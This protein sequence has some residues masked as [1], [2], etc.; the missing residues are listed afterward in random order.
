[1][2]EKKKCLV[3]LLLLLLLAAL[4]GGPD[5]I[6]GRGVLAIF[7]RI[8]R[9]LCSFHFELL[10]LLLLLLLLRNEQLTTCESAL[11]ANKTVPYKTGLVR[12]VSGLCPSSVTNSLDI[13]RSAIV[14]NHVEDYVVLLYDAWPMY[15]GC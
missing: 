9:L 7:F 2:S 5:S 10:L 3:L 1:M 14:D 4:A 13:G 12:C 15:H 6:P 8:R 11:S